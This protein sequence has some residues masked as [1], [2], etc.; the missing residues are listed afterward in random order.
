MPQKG[1]DATMMPF[2]GCFAGNRLMVSV[3][4]GNSART[5]AA[6]EYGMEEFIMKKNRLQISTLLTL[7]LCMLLLTAC[8]ASA[9]ESEGT[10][11]E[12]P[13]Q[14]STLR[15]RRKNRLPSRRTSR[16]RISWERTM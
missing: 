16:W 10:D 6:D 13:P 7:L 14:E 11:P 8:G 5:G 15:R 9:A 1:N 4:K 3:S 2:C 12:T